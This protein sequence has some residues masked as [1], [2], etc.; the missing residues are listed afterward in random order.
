[1]SA[2]GSGAGWFMVIPV[3]AI[4]G[5]FGIGTNQSVDSQP[6]DQT[7]TI[8]EYD[9]IR[10]GMSISRVQSV[11]GDSGEEISSGGNSEYY[12]KAL[13]WQNSDGSNVVVNFD[14]G[15]VSSKSQA[16]L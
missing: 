1:M 2:N 8:G 6:S 12:F 15:F 4:L 7:V 5:F 3:A 9:Q 13:S 11:I 10:T 16:G 14:N